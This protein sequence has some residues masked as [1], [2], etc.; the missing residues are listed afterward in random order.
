[1]FHRLPS[2]TDYPEMLYFAAMPHRGAARL[3]R[4]DAM[5]QVRASLEVNPD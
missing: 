3:H 5:P 1:M 4:F 2:G